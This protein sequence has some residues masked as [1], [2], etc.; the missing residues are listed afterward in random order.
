MMNRH[1][2]MGA[3]L[4]YVKI[5]VNE[6][7]TVTLTTRYLAPVSYDVLMDETFRTYINN[8]QNKGAAFFYAER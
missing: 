2:D 3:V 6:D 5:R 1:T 4:N 7:E 8:N